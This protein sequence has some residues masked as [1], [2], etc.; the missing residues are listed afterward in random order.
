MARERDVRDR[1]LDASLR[2][3]E[4]ELAIRSLSTQIKAADCKSSPPCWVQDARESLKDPGAEI[5][6]EYCEECVRSTILA[7]ERHAL[8]R[9]RLARRAAV[10]RAAAGFRG[11]IYG[12][13]Q[14]GPAPGSGEV[15]RVPQ[16]GGQPCSI[17]PMIQAST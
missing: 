10:L 9:Q 5:P 1:L 14:A 15:N 16:H 6:E 11:S 8:K 3:A 7:R 2:W 12:A 17:P 13:C 4:N